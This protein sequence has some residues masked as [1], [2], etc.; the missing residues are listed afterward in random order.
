MKIALVNDW[1]T[2]HG[3]ELNVLLALADIYADAPIYTSVYDKN[4]IPELAK[5]NVITTSLQKWPFATKMHKMMPMLRPRA[6][7]DLDLS[8]YDVVISSSHA[9]AKGVITKPDTMHICYCHTPTRYYWSDYHEYKKRME[10]GILNPLARFM[11]PRAIHKLR[12]W[13]YLAAQRVDHFIANSHYVA[14]RI[15]KY[16]RRD[17]T[18]IYPPVDIE[19]HVYDPSITKEDFYFTI[20]RLIP[21]KR[22]DILVEAANK[23][24]VKLKIAGIGPELKRLQKLAGPTVEVLG[25]INDNEKIRLMQRAKGF[26]FAAE[27]DFGIVPVEAMA[28]GTPVLAYGKGGLAESVT[29]ETGILVS[30]QDVNSFVREIEQMESR[31]FDYAIIRKHA[32]KFSKHRFQREIQEFVA[33][34]LIKDE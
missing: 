14:A 11:M 8:G 29:P 15:N 13:D 19:R 20:S 25:Y 21:Y 24:K 32:E 4:K 23:A 12:Q 31:T 7:E 9:E 26:L 34:S 17:A 10:F 30:E 1:L 33:S 16:Y 3:G 6:F 2:S 22:F 5:R 27:E 18:V 28:C